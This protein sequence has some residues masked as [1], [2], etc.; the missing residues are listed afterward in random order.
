M[1][2]FLL[3]QI[4]LAAT[5][6]PLVDQFGREHGLEPSRAATVV[7]LVVTAKQLRSLKGWELE[8]QKRLAGVSF[9]R[10]ADVPAQPPVTWERVAEKLRERVPS[11]VPIGIDLARSWATLYGL[12]TSEV[13]VLVFA[14]GG[15]LAARFRGRRSKPLVEQVVAAVARVPRSAAQAQP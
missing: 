7:A 11:Q 2:A 8:L 6:P 1:T 14:P 13:N 12:D 15:E 5:P 10:I 3:L 9:L 4:A